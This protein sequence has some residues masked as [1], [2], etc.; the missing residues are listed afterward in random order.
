MIKEFEGRQL[1]EEGI[2]NLFPQKHIEQEVETG[3]KK[4]ECGRGKTKVDQ[5]RVEGN[6]DAGRT[7][8]QECLIGR[9]PENEQQAKEGDGENKDPQDV[10]LPL[11]LQKQEDDDQGPGEERDRF[12]ERDQCDVSAGCEQDEEGQG[13]EQHSPHP[14]GNARP[15]YGFA[16][17]AQDVQEQQ[18]KSSEIKSGRNFQEKR[19]EGNQVVALSCSG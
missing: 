16:P 6:Q 17:A 5:D 13:M 4:S 19:V 18:E 11:M 2:E 9:Y 10:G 15:G 7:G 8:V 3:N 14:C 12:L 1:V